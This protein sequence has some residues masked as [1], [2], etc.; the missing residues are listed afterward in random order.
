[1]D[2]GG[3]AQ[4]RHRL[5]FLLVPA[6]FSGGLAELMPHQIQSGVALSLPTAVQ[7]W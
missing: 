5:G 4:R 3:R 7:R 2:C 6:A 1:M